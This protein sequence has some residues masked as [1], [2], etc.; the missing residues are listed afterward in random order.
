MYL[1]IRGTDG[2]QIGTIMTSGFT[3]GLA[4][5]GATAGYFLN[6]AV[7]GG[8]GA[9]AGASGILASQ[10][11]A[12]AAPRFRKIPLTDGSTAARKGD[13]RFLDSQDVSAGRDDREPTGHRACQR[14]QPG[15]RRQARQE[16]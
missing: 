9:Y 4:P 6:F 1:E 12:D 13:A 14:R 3:G 2:T 16:R 7:T 8:T 15:N 11:V 5:P 10:V